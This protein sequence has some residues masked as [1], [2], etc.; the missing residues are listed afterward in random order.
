MFSFGRAKLDNLNISKEARRGFVYYQNGAPYYFSH[1]VLK[2][3]PYEHKNDV[4]SLG[5][6]FYK[7]ITLSP[8]FG[9]KGMER[10]FN[11]VCKWQNSRIPVRFCGDLFKTVQ[12]L[13][14]DNS[15]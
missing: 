3:K 2:D 12:H 14:I 4:W 1:E 6:L 5:G 8:A 11:K 10:L 7:I 13:L 15:I 9:V